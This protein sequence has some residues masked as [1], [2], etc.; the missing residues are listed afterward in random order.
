VCDFELL[1]ASILFAEISHVA[2]LESSVFFR[3]DSRVSNPGS[4]TNSF[5]ITMSSWPS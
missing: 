5:L 4:M 3:C 2:L 1:V